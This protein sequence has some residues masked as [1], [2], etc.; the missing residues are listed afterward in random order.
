MA[1]RRTSRKRS[2][3]SRTKSRKVS[4][5]RNFRAALTRKR[6]RDHFNEIRLSLQGKV[7]TYDVPNEII[8]KFL[9]QVN[10]NGIPIVN[11]RDPFPIPFPFTAAEALDTFLTYCTQLWTQDNVDVTSYNYSIQQV[12]EKHGFEGYFEVLKI[13]HFMSVDNSVIEWFVKYGYRKG[14]FKSV[15]TWEH[16][17]LIN[18]L[19]MDLMEEISPILMTA[20][21]T[22]TDERSE[23]GALQRMLSTRS[24]I[25]ETQS[26]WPKERQTPI[27][28][29]I[30]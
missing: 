24:T 23:E 5:R 13:L 21:P 10:V 16:A 15:C 29:S 1:P 28:C 17:P 14:A 26:S 19:N 25:S 20:E 6:K 27:G 11:S 22:P 9:P 30:M 18:E 2:K 3:R 4:K 8:T 7:Y 12:I